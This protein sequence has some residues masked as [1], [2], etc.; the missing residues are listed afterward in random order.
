MS[1]YQEPLRLPTVEQW[2]GEFM[3]AAQS[4]AE[5]KSSWWRRLLLP[6][7]VIAALATTGVAT[8]AI[9][10]ELNEPD[11]PPFKGEALGYI[12]LETG[13]PITCPDGSLLTYTPP[14]GT[15]QYGEPECPDGSVPPVYTE[16]FRELE[17]YLKGGPGGGDFGEPAEEGPRFEFALPDP[18]E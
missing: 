3:V 16:Q 10:S 13:E 5:R 7:A 11:L 2:R 17:D 6:L 18:P 4:Y 1:E 9:V 14:A 12:N 15:R 8:A